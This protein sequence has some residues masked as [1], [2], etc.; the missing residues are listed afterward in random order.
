LIELTNLSKKYGDKEALKSLYLKV[1]AGEIY[2][3]LGPNG[4]GKTTTIKIM[5]GLLSPTTGDVV[6]AGVRMLS[7]PA[8]A[9]SLIGYIPDNPFVYDKLTGMEYLTLVGRLYGLDDRTIEERAHVWLERFALEEDRD[10]LLEGYSHGMKH[11]LLFTSAFIHEPKVLIVDEPMTGLD[12]RNTRVLKDIF[13]E[14]AKKGTTIFMSTHIL[15]V[16]ESIATRI[17]IINKGE[18]LVTGTMDEITRKSGE[19]LDLETFFLKVTE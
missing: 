12:P 17:G 1:G 10:N 11:K 9:K 13:L 6:I 8:R 3:Y 2:A 5:T 16:A 7:E 14:L 19:G 18:L 15:S 4:A